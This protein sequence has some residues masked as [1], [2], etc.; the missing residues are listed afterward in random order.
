MLTALRVAVGVVL[1]AAF[2]TAMAAQKGGFGGPFD[3]NNFFFGGG[4][5]QNEVSSSDKG[6]GYQFFG[7]YEFGELARDIKLDVEAGYM[8]TGNMDT[9]VCVPICAKAAAKAK[10]LWSTGVVR[11]V[12][13][14]Q[15]E[16]IGRAGL[17]VGDD[18]GLLVG[19]GAG[20]NINKQSSLRFEIVER[21]TVSS[22]QFNFVFR[23]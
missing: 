21:D 2:S 17:D 8:N 19:A 6:T 18:D 12:L 15:W 1:M 3:P 14:P 16:I 13:N 23:P 9:E 10:G 5:S 7:G 11:F 22:I 20:F 4:L